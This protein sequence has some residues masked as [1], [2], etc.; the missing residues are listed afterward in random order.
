MRWSTRLIVSA[1]ATVVSTVSLGVATAV[2]QSATAVAQSAAVPAAQ[3]AAVPAAQSAAVPDGSPTTGEDSP[4]ESARRAAARAQKE[5]DEA[6]KALDE[7]QA[8][9]AQKTR[10]VEEL[11]AAPAAASSEAAP[12]D[13]EKEAQAAVEE[14]RRRAE[15]AERRADEA[16]RRAREAIARVEALESRLAYDRTGLFIGGSAFYAPEAFDQEH[17]LVVKSSKGATARIGYRFHPNFAFDVRADYLDKFEIHDDFA[18]GKID[19]YAITGN[20]RAFLFPKR[21]QPWLGVGAGAITTDFPAHYNDGVKVDTNGKETDPIFR[22]AAGFDEYLSSSLV[23]TVEAAFNVV[24]DHRDY[25]NYG[26]LAV[27]LDYRF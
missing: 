16:N 24:G 17:G 25:I 6:R 1:L 10:R 15:Q 27:G 18:A 11:E 3:S 23:L 13:A 22:V 26:Q 20:V 19:G 12:A 4:V 7:A 9:V 21:F 2:A 14:A 5:L 8:R